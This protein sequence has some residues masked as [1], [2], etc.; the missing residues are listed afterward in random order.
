MPFQ[1]AKSLQVATVNDAIAAYD[2]AREAVQL[3]ESDSVGRI[4]ESFGLMR[5]RIVQA[6]LTCLN[7]SSPKMIWCQA[8]PRISTR[9]GITRWRASALQPRPAST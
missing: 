2:A 8:T 7:S 1:L 4:Q 9:F 6:R 5:G 3:F